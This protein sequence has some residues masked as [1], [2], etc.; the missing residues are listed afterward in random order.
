MH[1][2]R[3]AIAVAALRAHGIDSPGVERATRRLERDLA[4]ALDGTRLLS[5]PE[6]PALI[7]AT[8]ALALLSGVDCRSELDP[9]AKRVE[10]FRAQPWHAAQVATAWPLQ[11]VAPP[12]WP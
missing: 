9:R 4:A 8:L 10:D 1:H 6:E 11:A 5:F 12:N 2:G 3:A 7:A